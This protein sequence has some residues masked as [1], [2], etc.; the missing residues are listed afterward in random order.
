MNTP[1]AILYTRVSTDEQAEK[2]TSLAEQLI[3]CGRKAEQ[4]GARSRLPPEDA[5]VSARFTPRDP[6]RKPLCPDWN[7]DT[8]TL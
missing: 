2:G 3:A 6:A 4:I 8:A 1:R 5:G 7:P